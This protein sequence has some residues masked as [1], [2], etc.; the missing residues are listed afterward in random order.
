MVRKYIA[1]RTGEP[2]NTVALSASHDLATK[3]HRRR[4]IAEFRMESASSWEGISD[5]DADIEAS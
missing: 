3:A 4:E 5:G 2:P 1:D